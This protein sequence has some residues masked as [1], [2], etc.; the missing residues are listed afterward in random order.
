MSRYSSIEAEGQVAIIGERE[1]ERVKTEVNLP[2]QIPRTIDILGGVVWYVG[3][4]Q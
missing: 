4:E 3:R 1:L 2:Q